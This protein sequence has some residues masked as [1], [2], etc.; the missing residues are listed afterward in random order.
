MAE[1]DQSAR[2]PRMEI[3]LWW[4]IFAGPLGWAIDLAFSYSLNQHVCSTGHL[5]VLHLISAICF[6]GPLS[7]FIIALGNH[8]RFRGEEEGPRPRDRAYFQ[9]LMGMLF[10]VSFA[11]V[12]IATSLP[13]WILS[14][15]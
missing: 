2:D 12:I 11:V 15:S 13:R 4:G 14:C 10:S 9:S 3:G 6:L 8:R 7:G 1:V 5:Y